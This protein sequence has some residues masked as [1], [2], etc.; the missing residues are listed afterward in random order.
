MLRCEV[1]VSNFPEKSITKVN[2]SL[3]FA[4]REDGRYQISRKKALGS[5]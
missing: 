4:L 5:T 3:L 1:G 2:S